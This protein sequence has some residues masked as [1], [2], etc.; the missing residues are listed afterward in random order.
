[1][2]LVGEYLVIHQTFLLYKNWN[3]QNLHS[4]TNCMCYGCNMD[5]NDLA[6]MNALALGPITIV[7]H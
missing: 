2:V 6:D 5:M 3:L 4:S 1:M 7:M